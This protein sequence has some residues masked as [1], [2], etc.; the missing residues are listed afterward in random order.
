[1]WILLT[2]L[3]YEK[4][5]YRY[6]FVRIQAVSI[7]SSGFFYLRPQ[8]RLS[9]FVCTKCNRKSTELR[10]YTGTSIGS[11]HLWR[12]NWSP[13]KAP[14]PLGGAM[15]AN[16]MTFHRGKYTVSR[17]ARGQCCP[18]GVRASIGKVKLNLEMSLSVPSQEIYPLKSSQQARSRLAAGKN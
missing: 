12:P 8:S 13:K 16:S 18:T 15:A 7:T 17:K 6:L 1:M 2:S 5:Q 4:H 9:P 11:C 3:P 10:L 14:C